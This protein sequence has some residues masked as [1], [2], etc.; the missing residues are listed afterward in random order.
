M[1]VVST[2]GWTE[3]IKEFIKRRTAW[4]GMKNGTEDT[5]GTRSG[6]VMIQE[7]ST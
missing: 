5:Y 7:N 2:D 6:H 4:T 1:A 3:C